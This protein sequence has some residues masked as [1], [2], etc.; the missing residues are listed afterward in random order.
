MSLC[1]LSSS[2]PPAASTGC[3]CGLA[4]LN[5]WNL[6]RRPLTLRTPEPEG[7]GDM[8]R[9]LNVRIPHTYIRNIIGVFFT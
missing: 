7:E 5:E 6:E 3:G 2:M 9:N 4:P 1:T 8:V